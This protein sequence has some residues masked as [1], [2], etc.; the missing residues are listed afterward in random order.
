MT[1][2]REAYH[3]SPEE[4]RQLQLIELELLVEIDRI[5]KK[6]GI[7]YILD[8][9]TLLGAVRH[10]GFIPWDDD[11]DVAFLRPE[12]EKFRRAC[13]AELDIERFYFQDYR[14]TPGYRWGYGKLRRKNTKFIRL[15]QEDMP[16][17]Q[18]VCIDVFPH[19]NMPEIEPMRSFHDLQCFLYRK[20]FW[21]EIGKNINSGLT[22]IIYQMLNKIPPPK[23]YLSYDHFISEGSKLYTS[24]VR[25]LTYPLPKKTGFEKKWYLELQE[26]EFEGKT[27]PGP[28]DFNG[29]LSY[30]YSPDYMQLPPESQRK[31]H[32]VSKLKLL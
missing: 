5:C 27:F 1:E 8:G 23:I 20:L 24:K 7:N 18:G 9:G 26:F 17:E 28:K 29:Y 21:S 16:Y 32:P 19:D 22:K 30:H 3:L 14:N 2:R 12:Y 15:H 4:L 11:A 10:K 13:E 31:V 25:C 6:C